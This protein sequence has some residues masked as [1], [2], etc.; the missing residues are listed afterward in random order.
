MENRITG[1]R[2]FVIGACVVLGIGGIASLIGHKSDFLI[3][4]SGERITF[5]DYF[6]YYITKAGEPFGFILVGILLLFSS[7]KKTFLITFIGGVVTVVTYYLKMFFQHERPA[8]F[9]KSIDWSGPTHV[10]DYQM[11]IG[12]TSFPSGHSMAAWA[13]FTF[14]AASM[15]NRWIS[16]ASLLLASAV[17]L[18]RIYLMA[19]FLQD[20]VV[21]GIVGVGIGYGFYR[22]YQFWERKEKIGK[23][24]T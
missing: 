11:L 17:S 2:W 3:W 1:W 24:N 16:I 12:H 4:F 6:F 7:W 14:L 23:I 10:L 9:L 8:D 15:N 5:F 19:H 18:S 21:G 20:V 13:L 22:L